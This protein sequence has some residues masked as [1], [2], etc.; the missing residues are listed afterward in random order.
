M[1]SRTPAILQYDLTLYAG[2]SFS[3]SVTWKDSTGAIVDFTGGTGTGQ[4]KAAKADTTSVEDFTVTLGKVAKNITFSLTAA[5]VA[6]LT[7]R[8]KY[9]YDIQITTGSNIRTY[10]SGTLKTTADVTR[11]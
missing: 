7:L 1:A 11:P 2:D 10:I 6:A 9:Y 8:Q 5:E 3:A 4:I